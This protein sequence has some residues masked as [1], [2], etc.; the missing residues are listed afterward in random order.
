VQEQ[1]PVQAWEQVEEVV[2]RQVAAMVALLLFE[3][4]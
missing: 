4:A 2:A 1:V 3:P